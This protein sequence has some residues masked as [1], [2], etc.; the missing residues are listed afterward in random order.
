MDLIASFSAHKIKTSHFLTVDGILKDKVLYFLFDTGAAYS[1]IGSNSLFSD[2][3]AENKETFEKFLKDEIS[4]QKISPRKKILKTANNQS[5][6][7]YPCVSHDVSIE[8]VNG[9]DFYFDYSFDN[10]SL[11]L[12]GTSF[13]DDCAYS[14]SINSTLT[15]TSIKDNAGSSYYKDYGVLE[16]D[17]ATEKFSNYLG[18]E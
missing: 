6:T 16:F 3:E 10:I 11:P 1:L 14:H 2:N 7:T 18:T 8:G 13:S 15:I 4:A 5:I 17:M 9:F 12:L